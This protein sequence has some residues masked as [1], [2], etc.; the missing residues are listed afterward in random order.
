MDEVERF[1]H[2]MTR[3]KFATTPGLRNPPAVGTI[4]VRARAERWQARA[5]GASDMKHRRRDEDP[6]ASVQVDRER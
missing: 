3:Q 5:E 4:I 1:C 6:V 2:S